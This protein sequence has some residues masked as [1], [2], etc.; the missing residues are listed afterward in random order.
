MEKESGK[1]REEELEEPLN[2]SGTTFSIAEDA[3][4]NDSLYWNKVRPIPLTPEESITLKERD[5]IISISKPAPGSD[6]VK[7]K[8][9]RKKTLTDI[10]TG[11]SKTFSEGKARFT[12]GGLLDIE[13][14]NFS[15]VDGLHYINKKI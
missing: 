3:V 15:T 6:S 9:R 10:V 14:L 2:I 5:S 8:G 7:V 13:R 12:Y 4:K 1:G 11:T